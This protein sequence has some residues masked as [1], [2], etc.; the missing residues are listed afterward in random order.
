M[1]VCLM[2][3]CGTMTREASETVSVQEKWEDEVEPQEERAEVPVMN[4]KIHTQI[5][6]KTVDA[7]CLPTGKVAR[8]F[9]WQ[10]ED[11][12]WRHHSGVDIAY[13]KGE[14]VRAV[15]GGAVHRIERIAGGYAVEVMGEGDLW[16]Y[17]PLPEVSAAVG[18][19][20]EAGTVLGSIEEGS[21]VHIGRQHDGE[22]I[23][24]IS[25]Q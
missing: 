7:I 2:L 4:T 15:M 9:G 14:A 17:E 6:E 1:A 20:I 22:W 8:G 5:Q 19:R 16:R 25:M 23:E 11:G 21:V 13:A 10:E 18:T 24:P 12:I 3:L